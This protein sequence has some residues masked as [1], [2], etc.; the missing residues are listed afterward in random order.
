MQFDITRKPMIRNTFVTAL[1]M[2]A[3]TFCAS[4]AAPAA[5]PATGG[6]AV[7]VELKGAQITQADLELK[8]PSAMFQARTSFYEAERKVLLDLVDE[9]LLEQQAAKEGLAVPQLL[10][11]H[12]NATIAKDPSEDALRVY[13]EGL[14]TKE[15]YEAVRQKILDA[16]RD[17]RIAKAKA[18]YMQSLRAEAP[19]IIR[20]APPRAPISMKD[21]AVRGTA[22]ARLTL[23]EFADYECP[24][25]Q[26]IE[27]ILNRI[28]TEF[29]DQIAFAYKDYPLGMHPE[30]PKAAEAAHCAGTQGKF[31]EYHDL[32]FASKRMDLAS[33]KSDARDLKLD[34]AAFDACLAKNETAPLVKESSSE[35]ETL[36]LQGTPTLF[37]NG[38]YVSNSTY[39]GIR[40][41]IVEELSALGIHI[42]KDSNKAARQ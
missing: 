40:G 34:T 23:L 10:E 41:V 35:A 27:P 9:N 2:F 38:R 20:L 26:Q 30:A 5:D 1:A 8:R 14:D 31:W 6:D 13:Y 3:A 7:L 18:T 22:N 36:G 33:L 17:R 21:V 39:E 16:I 11:R 24:Y 4:G 15:P 28:E 37:V 19:A 32:I 12:V 42:N 25:C 29:K